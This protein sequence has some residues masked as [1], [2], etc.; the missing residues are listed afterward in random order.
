MSLEMQEI[1]RVTC[2]IIGVISNLRTPGLLIAHFFS[3]QFWEKAF[4]FK[5]NYLGK[6][7][8]AVKLRSPIFLAPKLFA[9]S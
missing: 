4:F 8:E 2:N 3:S 9:K 1:F 6:G 7:I 5:K